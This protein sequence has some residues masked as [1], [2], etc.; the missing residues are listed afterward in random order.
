MCWTMTHRGPCK[1]GRLHKRLD[2]CWKGTSW[3]RGGTCSFIRKATGPHKFPSLPS[4][5]LYLSQWN[6]CVHGSIIYNSQDLEAAQVSVSRR[7]DE[8]A[9]V[10]SHNGILLSHKKEGNL[11]LC[12]N[13]DEPGEHYAQWHKPVRERQTPYGLTHM[14]NLMNKMN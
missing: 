2:T 8:K 5:L 6:P 10:P 14:W 12:N 11:T 4:S 1:S 3:T 13:M 7:M 9:V